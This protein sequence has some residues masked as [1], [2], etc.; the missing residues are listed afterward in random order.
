MKNAGITGRNLAKSLGVSDSAV[1]LW[2][3]GTRTPKLATAKR[4]AEVLNCEVSEIWAE[5]AEEPV[6]GDY[7]FT[8][9]SVRTGRTQWNTEQKKSILNALVGW[10]DENNKE[11]TKDNGESN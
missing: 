11:E 8:L 5:R 4:I 6:S 3:K 2:L 1:S 10:D 7:S 9:E